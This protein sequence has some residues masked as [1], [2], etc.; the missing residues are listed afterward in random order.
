M[1]PPSDAPEAEAAPRTLA[2]GAYRAIR[3]DILWGRLVPGA[4]LRSDALRRDYGLGISPLREALTRLAADRLVTAV[5]QRGF[6]VAPIDAAEVADV[7]R[8]RI[9][10]EGD[11]LRLALSRGGIAWEARLAAAF[12]TLSRTERPTGPG[13]AAEAWGRAHH[14]F[15]RALID[16]C[17]SNWSLRLSEVL[18]F[19]AERYRILHARVPPTRRD[20]GVEHRDIFDAAMARDATEAVAC[21]SRHYERT[22]GH[23]LAQLDRANDRKKEQL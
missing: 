20:T 2:E 19:Q 11:A 22:A 4:P 13:A 16:G 17:G 23:V 10:I 3:D 5:E 21:L 9:L 18:Y 1:P 15:H 7:T 8:L 14:G 6:R 12:H